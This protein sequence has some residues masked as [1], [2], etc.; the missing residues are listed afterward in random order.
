M[1]DF[2]ITEIIEMAILIEQSGYAFYDKA[3]RNKYLKP[4]GKELLETLRDQERQHEHFFDDMLNQSDLVPV[5]FGPDQEIVNDY[6]KAIINYRI[7]DN[8]DAAIKK[9]NEAKDE[10]DLF[11]TAIDFEKDTLLF[12]Q[13][14]RDII[15]DSN[16]KVILEKIIKEEISHILW[17][18]LY[19]DKL[20]G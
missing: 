20:T 8:P 2:S 5:D 17:L 11:K 12:F 7:F 1:T 6:L 19:R 13:G 15:K 9:V 4:K 3:L 16:A 18:T 14:I 10:L